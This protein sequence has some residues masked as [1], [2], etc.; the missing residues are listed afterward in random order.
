MFKKNFLNTDICQVTTVDGLDT[1]FPKYNFEKLENYFILCKS[2]LKYIIKSLLK[3]I[4]KIKL[5]DYCLGHPADE[6]WTIEP[7]NI[8]RSFCFQNPSALSTEY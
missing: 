1:L 5:R 6:Y 4:Q 3:A 2:T 7:K 8:P